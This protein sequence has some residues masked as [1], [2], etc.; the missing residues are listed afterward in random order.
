[1]R[2]AQHLVVVKRY[3]LSLG[4]SAFAAPVLGQGLQAPPPFGSALAGEGVPSQL[5]AA[6]EIRR[7]LSE[8]AVTCDPK[9]LLATCSE[10]ARPLLAQS[11]F[12]P[13]PVPGPG[14]PLPA[15]SGPAATP[16]SVNASPEVTPTIWLRSSPSVDPTRLPLGNGR[17]V[18]D[19]PRKGYVFACDPFMYS[20]PTIIGAR[21]TGPWVD[22]AAGTYN[23][24][25]KIFDSGRVEWAGRFSV[26][27]DGDR[28]V[29]TGDGLPIR[30]VPTGLFPV[31]KDDP[32]F[33]FDPNPNAIGE[34]A[35]RFSVPLRPAFGPAPR[36]VY[37]EVGITLDGVPL[38]TGLDSSGRDEN[39]YELNDTCNGKP[40]PGGGYHRHALSE[41]TPGIGERATVVGYALD[42]FPITGPY[43]ANGAELTTERLDECHGTTSE[44][45]WNGRRIGSYHY[46]LTRDFPY[47]IGC[48][49][50]TPTRN[51]FP[52]LPGAPPQMR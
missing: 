43:D 46:V 1:M 37:K 44:I 21:R 39:A 27:P 8:L 24:T 23:V 34:Q 6:F 29:I 38:H 5:S 11:P 9:D 15:P 40:Q 12:P 14:A 30:G 45:V 33:A 19:R 28:R 25:R 2:P 4:I 42:G 16:L 41:C 32:A 50:G 20:M 3:L 35:I 7:G 17:M 26:V 36:C 52:P 47:S 22:E 10:S 49:R 13:G 31:R 51:A 48:F 18:T